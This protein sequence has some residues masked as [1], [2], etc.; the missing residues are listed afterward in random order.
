MVSFT[1]KQA[2][3]DEVWEAE[4]GRHAISVLGDKHVDII[5]TDL[6]MPNMDGF[7]LLRH[8]RQDPNYKFIPILMLTT[9]GDDSKKQKGKDA[10]A[11]GW[12]VKPFV[13]EKLIKVVKKVAN[14]D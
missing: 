10:G 12:I 2:G 8:L 4:D 5:I 7:E 14:I 3:F 13:P 6:N 1:L 11:T 9:E